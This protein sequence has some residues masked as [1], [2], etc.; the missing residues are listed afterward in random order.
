MSATLRRTAFAVLL[1]CLL[2]A[3]TAGQALA[4]ETKAAG[5]GRQLVVGWGIEPAYAGQQNHVQLLVTD[6]DSGKPVKVEVDR[7]QVTV[8]YGEKEIKLP[9]EPGYDAQTNAV[10]PGEY[11][12]AL[13]PTAPGDYTFRITGTIAGEKVDGSFTSGPKTFSP[14]LDPATVQFPVKAP[15]VTQVA[16]RLESQTSR[17]ATTAGLK[18]ALDEARSDASSARTL[19]I[20]GIAVGVLGLAAATL[21]LVRRKA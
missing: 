6:S 18:R 4:H 17:F 14:V 20:A 11:W 13:I 12:A 10:A 5:D 16:K 19:A 9:L 21:A 2:L 8:T 15:D 1:G 3:L 7:L